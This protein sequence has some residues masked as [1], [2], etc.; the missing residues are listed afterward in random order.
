MSARRT[1][2][3]ARL[4]SQERAVPME[5]AKP[6]IGPAVWHLGRRLTR[7]RW[8]SVCQGQG[9][10]QPH[11]LIWQDTDATLGALRDPLH[12]TAETTLWK[13]REGNPGPFVLPVEL[14]QEES[15]GIRRPIAKGEQGDVDL[16]LDLWLMDYNEYGNYG[17]Q[18]RFNTIVA[19]ADLAS[20]LLAKSGLII[21]GQSR[22][23]TRDFVPL[24]LPSPVHALRFRRDPLAA[25]DPRGVLAS[26]PTVHSGDHEAEDD[27]AYLVEVEPPAGGVRT[28]TRFP[29][30]R[31][32][33]GVHAQSTPQWNAASPEIIPVGSS[34]TGSGIA[35]HPSG[36]NWV[37]V[38]TSPASITVAS[39][40]VRR[41]ITRI[42]FRRQFRPISSAPGRALRSE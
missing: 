26:N 38:T 8:E 36:G 34:W 28:V 24:G 14:Q 1:G 2:G 11:R 30:R 40:G 27:E 3:R 16:T 23:A 6:I 31:S 22:T 20:M 15:R 10:R 37:V 35:G 12:P 9:Y 29:L 4:A 5:A 25:F 39:A 17:P 41:R 18:G 13:S 21:T 42:D 7:W 32:A 33:S 19:F